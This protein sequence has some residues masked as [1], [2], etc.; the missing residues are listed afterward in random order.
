MKTGDG[1]PNRE[2]S[3][4]LTVYRQNS[5]SLYR[6]DLDKSGDNDCDQQIGTS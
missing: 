6:R 1:L 2:K 5:G 4:Y 3:Q